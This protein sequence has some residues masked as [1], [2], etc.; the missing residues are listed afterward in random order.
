MR[1]VVSLAVLVA[2]L[3]V[4]CQSQAHDWYPVECCN[5]RDCYPISNDEVALV[6]GGYKLKATGEVFTTR[7]VAG[8]KQVKWSPDGG[9]HRC[10]FNGDR[11]A[12]S[13]ICLFAPPGAF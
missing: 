12:Q 10:S 6:P 1:Y 9:Y 11:K 2:A 3:A 8:S 5:Q 13:S 7:P 4:S